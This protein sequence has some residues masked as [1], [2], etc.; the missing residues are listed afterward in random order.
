MCGYIKYGV[1]TSVVW[2]VLLVLMAMLA[3]SIRD[4]EYSYFFDDGTGG[5]GISVLIV[6]W[7]LIWFGIGYH[8]RKKYVE[9]RTFYMKATSLDKAQFNKEFIS[10]YVSK[11]AKMLAIVFIT[12]VPW[13]V[14][15]YVNG[16]FSMRDF[17][18]IG[19]LII[20]AVASFGTYKLLKK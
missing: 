16:S 11:H 8:S 12:A 13:Y 17:I 20:L 3:A 9:E 2:N 1:I 4:V 5:F 6:I 15:G 14:L 19:V 18:I 7:S 10:Y